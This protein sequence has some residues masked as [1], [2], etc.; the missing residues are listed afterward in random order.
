M[1]GLEL[2]HDL[3]DQ[4]WREK[5]E[6]IATTR[7]RHDFNDTFA[8]E[9][10]L[11]NVLTHGEDINGV[12]DVIQYILRWFPPAA[13]WLWLRKRL[14][15]YHRGIRQLQRFAVAARQ[16]RLELE[17]ALYRFWVDC[18]HRRRTLPPAANAPLKGAKG[19]VHFDPAVHPTSEAVK[20]Q[21]IHNMYLVKRR[22]Y[23]RGYARYLERYGQL[24][25]REVALAEQLRK[26]ATAP[27][28]CIITDPKEAMERLKKLSDEIYQHQKTV[29]VFHFDEN[30]I[31]FDEMVRRGARMGIAWVMKAED[32][33]PGPLVRSLSSRGDD[34]GVPESR[35][36][37]NLLRRRRSKSVSF[38]VEIPGDDEG[39]KPPQPLSLETP[40][41]GHRQVGSPRHARRPGDDRDGVG[42]RQA[43]RNVPAMRKLP[44]EPAELSSPRHGAP[45]PEASSPRHAALARPHTVG[46]RAIS[47]S[48]AKL[49]AEAGELS[50][51]RHAAHRPEASSP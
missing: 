4:K 25:A 47:Q 30:T 45:R 29:P 15:T 37:G 14:W 33:G 31:C 36:L 43:S 28:T 1:D 20:R 7:K 46:T 26:W 23:I 19:R 44:L 6:V 12:V 34:F 16:Q 8:R 10:H 38:G 48:P 35:S 42:P 3:R 51:P 17:E 41:S 24:R 2:L 5:L 50:S 22:A 40:P 11:R 18:E 32:P 27:L 9:H 21:M 13:V 39:D 49:Q